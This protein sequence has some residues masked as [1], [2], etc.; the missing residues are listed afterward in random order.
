MRHPRTVVLFGIVRI[1][2][3]LQTATVDT[4]ST[5]K[6]MLASSAFAMLPERLDALV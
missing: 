6:T 5:S 4:A 2:K 3:T 1:R